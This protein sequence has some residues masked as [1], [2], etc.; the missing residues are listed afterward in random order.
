M[1]VPG[2]VKVPMLGETPLDQAVAPPPPGGDDAWAE[3]ERENPPAPL[4]EAP[5]DEDDAPFEVPELPQRGAKR[6]KIDMYVP[7]KQAARVDALCRYAKYHFDVNKGETQE[8]ILK[9]G[10]NNEAEVMR[11]LRAMVEDQ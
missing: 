6:R 11:A 3:A 7:T 2:K 10:L 1:A 9:Y 4:M 5:E 8:L